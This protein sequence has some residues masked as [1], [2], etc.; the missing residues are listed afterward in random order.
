MDRFEHEGL[1]PRALA[2]IVGMLGLVGIVT[3]AFDIGYVRNSLIVDGNAA[4]TLHNILTHESMYRAG[5]GAHL[6]EV[7]CNVPGEIISFILF[8][9]VNPVIAGL[10]LACGLVGIS[11]EATG[12]LNA[13][14]PLTLVDQ[15]RSLGA[16]PAEQLQALSYIYTRLDDAGLLISFA[17]YGLDEMSSGF[18]M[19]RSHFLPRVIGALLGVAGLCYFSHAFLSFVAPS[20]D[21]RLMPYVLFPCL[22]GEGSAAVWMAVVGLNVARYR[23]WAAEPLGRMAVA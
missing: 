3:G 19:F 2:R 13:Y 16:I 17:F 23:G 6:L 12:M 14:M 22:P 11:V 20:V 15:A 8:R 1:G 10:A 18:L 21:A 7:V 4:A 9:R 5:F